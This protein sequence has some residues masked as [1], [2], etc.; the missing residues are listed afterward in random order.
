MVIPVLN[1]VG[2]LVGDCEVVEF[3]S[4]GPYPQPQPTAIVSVENSRVAN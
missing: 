2:T 1:A 3:G 4:E